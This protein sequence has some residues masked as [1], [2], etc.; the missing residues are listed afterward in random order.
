MLVRLQAHFLTIADEIVSSSLV[1]VATGDV[2]D[3]PGAGTDSLLSSGDSVGLVVG[4]DAV[5]HVA[6]EPS[7]GKAVLEHD[8]VAEAQTVIGS[9]RV[10]HLMQRWTS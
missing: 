8:G 9:V 4:G 7:V 6:N 5:A 1:G 3:G 2:D 10:G